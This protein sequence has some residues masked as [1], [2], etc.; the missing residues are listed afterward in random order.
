MKNEYEKYNI[1][2]VIN[3]SGKMTILGGSKV[4]EDVCEQ[5]SFGDRKSTRLNSS[6]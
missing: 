4:S 2:K 6:H 1:K 3:A 5:M